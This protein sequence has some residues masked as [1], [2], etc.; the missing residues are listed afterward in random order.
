M[1]PSATSSLPF[2]CVIAPVNAPRSCPKSSLSS[3]VSVK[4]AQLMATKGP[5]ARR[6]LRCSARA[7]N[8]LPVPLSPRISTLELDGATLAIWRCRSRSLSLTPTM[9]CSIFSSDCRRSFS[10]CSQPRMVAFSQATAAMPATA[11]RSWRCPSSNRCSPSTDSR[12]TTAA[13]SPRTISGAA[14]DTARPLH[15]RQA[16]PAK[17]R[18]APASRSNTCGLG[19]A[20]SDRRAPGKEASPG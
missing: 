13:T 5:A 2:F 16:P 20:A 17:P 12:Y 9:P 7:I 18:H 8:S 14:E 4:A 6:L 1:P 15:Y 10:S 3:S 11:V 19:A